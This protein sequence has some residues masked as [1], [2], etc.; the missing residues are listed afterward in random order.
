MYK[1][2]VKIYL[3]DFFYIFRLFAKNKKKLFIY[4]L[5]Y[6]SMMFYVKIFEKIKLIYC[7]ALYKQYILHEY[8]L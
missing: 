3:L 7:A 6:N 8:V 5:Y 2:Y 4:Y 1:N